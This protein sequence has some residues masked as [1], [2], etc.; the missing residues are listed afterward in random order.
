MYWLNKIQ[1]R[2]ESAWMSGQ[3][4]DQFPFHEPFADDPKVHVDGLT[5]D[6]TDKTLYYLRI[7]Q[8]KCEIIG[9]KAHDRTS[10]KVIA[11]PSGVTH[12]SAFK[13][14]VFWTDIQGQVRFCSSENCEETIKL[15]KNIKG[16]E[17]FHFLHPDAQPKTGEVN[18]CEASN[19]GCSDFCL[20]I[21]GDPWRVCSCP[22]GVKLSPDNLTCDPN[23]IRKALFVAAKNSL[24]YISLDTKEFLPR[25]IDFENPDAS[26]SIVD[27]DYD[28]LKENV[29]WLDSENSRVFR[30]KL[31]GS[32]A[33]IVTANLSKDTNTFAV[34]WLGR[35]LFF[36]DP[37][38]GRIEVEKLGDSSSRRPIISSGLSNPCCLQ[39]DPQEGFLYFAN[40]Y[41][42][43]ARIEKA[44]LDGSRR[45][46]LFTIPKAKS[47]SDLIVD[48][49]KNEVYWIDE[50]GSKIGMVKLDEVNRL[51]LIATNFQNINS[52][53]KLGNTLY[54]SSQVGRSVTAIEMDAN[55][56]KSSEGL[57]TNGYPYETFDS[58]IFHQTALKAVVLK[59]QQQAMIARKPSGSGVEVGPST[60]H[61]RVHQ[62]GCFPNNGG[63]SHICVNL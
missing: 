22:A 29:Y 49:E 9:C 3:F 6:F 56:R 61:S 14:R 5:M 32:D 17:R 16:F 57:T 31:D 50:E 62:L 37:V 2:I 54:C 21:P 63:C 53:T 58:V 12:L 52:L 39:I 18:P 23:G 1:N 11:T 7:W 19:G 25:R 60:K 34:D 42:D 10:C 44:L 8:D 40:F 4:L 38:K 15:V 59:P 24:F 28:V 13:G 33:E 26:S 20:L 47:L 35:N 41:G 48:P 46:I 55:A 51:T 27:V 30:S 36:L 43:R 45:Q